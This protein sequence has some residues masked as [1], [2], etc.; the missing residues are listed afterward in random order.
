[1]PK[2]TKKPF[3]ASK[4]GEATGSAY[5]APN[6]RKTPYDT[7]SKKTSGNATNMRNSRLNPAQV[8]IL[9]EWVKK[10]GGATYPEIT[11]RA[12]AILSEG[13]GVV[14]PLNTNWAWNFLR[15]YPDLPGPSG[16]RVRRRPTE[17]SSKKEET[18]RGRPTEPSSKQG[19]KVR[20]RPTEP[21]SK[22]EKTLVD[23]VLA[24]R[25]I[26]TRGNIE[27][28]AVEILR[29]GGNHRPLDYRWIE[30]F[31]RKYSPLPT[32]SSLLSPLQQDALADWAI[33]LC[34]NKSPPDRYQIRWEATRVQGGTA[35]S[36]PISSQ[37]VNAFLRQ[38]PDVDKAIAMANANLAAARACLPRPGP[39]HIP[40]HP[41]SR[42]EREEGHI[43]GR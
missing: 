3:N 21:S 23:W 6:R 41:I 19:E 33:K 14:K 37:W 17:P 8:E 16:S 38:H 39:I 25:D 30:S 2:Y 12:A 26:P 5:S 28:R 32:G 7:P 27:K 22:Q 13:G 40:W 36:K 18:V 11:Q 34:D 15:R 24:Q 43:K 10:Q 29:D 20:G 42:S 35:G 4:D 31:V 9:K 1:M